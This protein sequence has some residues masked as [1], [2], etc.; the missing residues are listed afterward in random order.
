M[1]N[2]TGTGN[3]HGT[4]QIPAAAFAAATPIPDGPGSGPAVVGSVV[5]G[6]GAGL[7]QVVVTVAD[8]T[9]RHEARTTTGPDGDYRVLL[10]TGGTYLVVAAAGPY[11]PHA[12]LVAVADGPARH[13]IVL[14]GTSGVVG[15]VLVTDRS[16]TAHGVA[17][18][19][20]TLID[21]RGDA[22]AAGV[23]DAAG[24]YHLTG[25]PDGGYTLTAA[26]AGHQPVAVSVRLELGTTV[27]RDLE[28]PHR[29]RLIG[30]VVAASDGHLVAE[31]MATLVDQTGTVVGSTVTGPDGTFVFEDLP[32]GTYTLTASGYAPVAQVVHVA[33]GGQT[34]N[35]MELGTRT[36]APSQAP[37]PIPDPAQPPVSDGGVR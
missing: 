19:T 12:A 26:S 35:S 20:V 11:Q 8:L 18:A 23:T 24:R 3:G 6:N 34:T 32:E 30:T 25:V 28:L 29:S 1:A 13:D 9:G 2:G 16:G 15:A 27:E 31:A 37:V 21:V 17:G 5:R 36:A 4:Q 22:A 33:A 7:G 10:R 14:A